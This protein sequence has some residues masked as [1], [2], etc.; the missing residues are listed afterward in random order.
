MN[1]DGALG[2]AE[3]GTVPGLTSAPHI[4]MRPGLFH[5]DSGHRLAEDARDYWREAGVD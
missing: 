2:R 3:N 5:E 1:Y 4:R